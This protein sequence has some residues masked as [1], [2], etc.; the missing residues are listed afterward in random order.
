MG[1]N[2][3]SQ[4]NTTARFRYF[5]YQDLMNTETK[6]VCGPLSEGA[7]SL[8]SHNFHYNDL[9]EVKGQLIKSAWHEEMDP[10]FCN[11]VTVS[12]INPGRIS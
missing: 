10:A 9:R 11:T 12:I 1:F 8:E 3:P 2:G 7:E 4:F 5:T 6:V